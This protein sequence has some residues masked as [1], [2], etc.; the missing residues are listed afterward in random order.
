MSDTV[1]I[2]THVHLYSCHDLASCLDCARTNFVRAGGASAPGVLMLCEAVEEDRFAELAGCTERHEAVGRWRLQRTGERESLLA[3]GDDDALL[4][5]IAGRQIVTTDGLEVLALGTVEQFTEGLSLERA[6]TLA[7]ASGALV[8][9]PYGVG[10][11][12]GRR[13]RLVASALRGDGEFAPLAGDNANRLTWVP[14]PW[15]LRDVSLPGSDPLPL[16]GQ[17]RRIGS[18]GMVLRLQLDLSAPAAQLKDMLPRLS[19][20]PRRFGSLTGLSAF[21]RAQIAMQLRK[22]R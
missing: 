8:V 7:R 11:W 21:V 3:R 9:L 1:L 6:V 22:R 5:L 18:Y 4:V 10:K 19:S 12:T 17:D 16:P 15:L 2:D 20:P 14:T 13:G